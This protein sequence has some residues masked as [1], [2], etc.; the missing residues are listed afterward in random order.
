ML[1]HSQRWSEVSVAN[2]TEFEIAGSVEAFIFV[3]HVK[4]FLGLGWVSRMRKRDLITST[5]VQGASVCPGV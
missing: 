3:S 5:P 4:T 1:I 2:T